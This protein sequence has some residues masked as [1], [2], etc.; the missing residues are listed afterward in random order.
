MKKSCYAQK[1]AASC[2]ETEQVIYPNPIVL[3]AKCRYLISRA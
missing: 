1:F 3:T 2:M